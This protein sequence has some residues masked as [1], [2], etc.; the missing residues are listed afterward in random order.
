M[1]GAFATPERQT[2]KAATRPYK[3]KSKNLEQYSIKLTNHQTQKSRD[4]A[5]LLD[6]N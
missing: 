1:D 6:K 4:Q 3:D 2:T 5:R